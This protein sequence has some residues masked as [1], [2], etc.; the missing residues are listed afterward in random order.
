VGNLGVAL[1]QTRH[2]AST[3]RPDLGAQSLAVGGT[4][5]HCG[6]RVLAQL[7]MIATRC[8]QSRAVIRQ[9]L[10]DA[11]AAGSDV[12]AELRHVGPARLQAGADGLAPEPSAPRRT[13]IGGSGLAHSCAQ[14]D[15]DD[16]NSTAHGGGIPCWRV[17]V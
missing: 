7:D 16:R 3:T 9:A 13:G 5:E 4:R 2:D 8:G 1:G 11:P 6:A 14:D 10:R 12:S 15:G 17:D